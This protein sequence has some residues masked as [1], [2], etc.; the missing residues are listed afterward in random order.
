MALAG[1][2]GARRAPT[3]PALF[4]A[5]ALALT[6]N[7][8]CQQEQRASV[9]LTVAGET[10]RFEIQ[11][12]LAEYWE[13]AGEADELRVTLASFPI[14]C[15]KFT[16]PPEG[17]AIITVSVLVPEGKR[18]A[19]GD[20]PWTGLESLG[21]TPRQPAV[22]YALPYVRVP[23]RGFALAPGGAVRVA[24]FEPRVHGRVAGLLSFQGVSD[25]AAA[26]T[27]LSGRFEA[28]LCRYS[29]LPAPPGAE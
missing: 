19:L 15:E 12:A 26:A 7:A 2:S 27:R 6:A 11:T 24:E 16:P 21:D 3:R 9:E 14:S 23:G 13:L 10:S 20:Y 5:A 18:L 4:C 28:K 17:Q 25:D 22:A 1:F 29:P 8:G